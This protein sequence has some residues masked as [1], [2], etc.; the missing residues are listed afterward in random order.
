MSPINN[1]Q[2]SYHYD[3]YTDF[4]CILDYMYIN[5]MRSRKEGNTEEF[6]RSISAFSEIRSHIDNDYSNQ[7]KY[8]SPRWRE[9]YR[10]K[11]K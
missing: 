7:L 3:L 4:E 1:T 10:I 2:E 8:I 11:L 6:E 9:K 5:M